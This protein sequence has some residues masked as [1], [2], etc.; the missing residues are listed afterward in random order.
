MIFVNRTKK[1]PESLLSEPTLS[2]AKQASDYYQTWKPG[3]PAFEEFT[4]YKGYDVQQA[5]RRDFNWKCAY[6][7]SP[8]E[9][10]SFG[11]EHYRPKGGVAG[12]DHPGYWWL[13]FEW[14]NL[15]PTC[16]PCNQGL[17][18]HIVTADM[19]VTAVE[20]FQAVSPAENHGKATQFPVSGVRFTAAFDDHFAEGPLLLDP[21][22]SNPEPELHWRSDSV[23]S[24]VEAAETDTGV[25]DAG[26]E[27]IKCVALKRLDLVQ[28]RTRLLERL[29]TQRIQIM[30]ALDQANATANR[31]KQIFAI[32]IA[33][34]RIADMRLSSDAKQPYAGMVRAFMSKF[35]AEF[36]AEMAARGYLVE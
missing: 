11:V 25:S 36:T 19:D 27:T 20:A 12:C 18:Q 6:C 15:L 26:G 23:F 2:Q 22:R 4:H 9:K 28:N 3:D 8:L 34:I 14:S 16:R 24:V 21:T 17:L 1:C 29:R 5:L 32:E 31:E 10:G 33:K 13:A 7:E 30:D 35:T